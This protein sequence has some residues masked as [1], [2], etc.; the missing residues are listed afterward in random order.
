M[1]PAMKADFA[2]LL[3]SIP[4]VQ[5]LAGDKIYP[6]QRTPGDD[7]PCVCYFLLSSQRVETM[8]GPDGTGY[9][10][11]QL[12]CWAATDDEAGRLA[13]VVREVLDG[14]NFQDNGAMGSHHVQYVEVAD[15]QD[16]DEPPMG[17]EPKGPCKTSL[18]ATVW[19]YE[20]P[21]GG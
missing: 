16:T 14:F 11:L 8:E 5:E 18:E 20:T 9:P 4:G 15:V 13:H 17:G 3:T 1:T 12:D 19:Y 7:L 2:T 10:R 21:I 6:R